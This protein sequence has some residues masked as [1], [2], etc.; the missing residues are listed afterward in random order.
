MLSSI[1]KYHKKNL[2]KLQLAN[3]RQKE[4]AISIILSL[5]HLILIMQKIILIWQK[6]QF[7]L[8][9]SVADLGYGE[10][11]SSTPNID[12]KNST[13]PNSF[14]G[15]YTTGS[16]WKISNAISWLQALT[17][18]PWK[19]C[20]HAFHASLRQRIPLPPLDTLFN[21][22]CPHKFPPFLKKKQL[23]TKNS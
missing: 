19:K 21:Y 9:K 12:W 6:G 10:V 14:L 15:K 1:G 13:S 18:K 22:L 8:L 2:H 16:G 4:H 11:S 20:K 5:Y 23:T 17:R 7:F 3:Y